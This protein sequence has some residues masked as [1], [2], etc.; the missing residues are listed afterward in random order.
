MVRRAMNPDENDPIEN[1]SYRLEMDLIASERARLNKLLEDETISDMERESAEHLLELYDIRATEAE[2]IRWRFTKEDVAQWRELAEHMYVLPM[3]S[4][5]VL[6][7]VRDRYIDG[8]LTAEQFVR[9]AESVMWMIR[10]EQE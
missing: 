2:G 1:P 4:G 8:Q 6:L 9:E 3:P 5:D 10:M 7:N